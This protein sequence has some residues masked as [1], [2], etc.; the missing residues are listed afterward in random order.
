MAECRHLIATCKESDEAAA[1]Y[2]KPLH[3]TWNKGVSKV[4]SMAR[5]YQKLNKSNIRANTETLIM[6]AQEQALKTRAVKHKIY[7]TVQDP[8]CRLCK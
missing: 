6:A 3:G 7:H 4:A 1:W 5:T 8:R 2:E